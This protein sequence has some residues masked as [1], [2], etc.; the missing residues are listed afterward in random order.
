MPPP[1]TVKCF[2]YDKPHVI[3]GKARYF[4][5]V[6]VEEAQVLVDHLQ[7]ECSPWVNPHGNCSYASAK[8]VLLKAPLL[9][10]NP[11]DGT[12]HIA[13]CGS[14]YQ[15]KG[16]NTHYLITNSP[17]LRQARSMAA[18]SMAEGSSPATPTMV[19]SPSTL[20]SLASASS[21]VR[22]PSLKKSTHACTYLSS[23]FVHRCCQTL[24]L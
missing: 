7:L 17:G 6:L 8:H 4:K 21:P 12:A 3:K 19:S 24:T 9:E 22:K 13:M 23:Y 11:I 16:V 2:S 5:P 18:P 1:V 10:G 14:A 15:R 20:C